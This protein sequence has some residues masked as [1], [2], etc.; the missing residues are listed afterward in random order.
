M[1]KKKLIWVLS[2]IV[3]GIVIF[4]LN[5]NYFFP[6]SSKN[7]HVRSE[8][9]GY[10]IA[11]YLDESITM[12]GYGTSGA[13]PKSFCSKE[14][15]IASVQLFLNDIHSCSR[16]PL[17]LSNGKKGFLVSFSHGGGM[18]CQSGCI[19]SYTYAVVDGYQVYPLGD[20]DTYPN[21]DSV[22]HF[23]LITHKLTVE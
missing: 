9:N 3:V 15:R 22:I 20:L 7:I 1:W 23:N 17:T 19:Y 16:R 6:P 21:K 10:H 8:E 14:A 2:F 11:Y 12:G 4:L 5:W 13:V 18:D